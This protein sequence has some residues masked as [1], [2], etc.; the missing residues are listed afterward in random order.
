MGPKTGPSD[1]A[2]VGVAA[3]VYAASQ[4]GPRFDDNMTPDERK[5]I[6]NGIWLCGACAILVD[7]DTE[8]FSAET[9]FTWKKQAE[10]RTAAELEGFHKLAGDISNTH[11]SFSANLGVPIKIELD[12]DFSVLTSTENLR[13]GAARLATG[14]T[15]GS[16]PEIQVLL[17]DLDGVLAHFTDPVQ[18]EQVSQAMETRRKRT[19]EMLKSIC[20]ASAQESWRLYLSDS[21]DYLRV[22]E[23]ILSYARSIGVGGGQKL[24]VFQTTPPELYASVFLDDQEV[25]SMLDHLGFSTMAHLAFGAGWRAAD[26]LPRQIIQDKVI[27]AI[28]GCV[29]PWKSTYS[30]EDALFRKAFR[31]HTWHIG[32]G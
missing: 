32:T 18:A 8:R 17:P 23:G 26:E 27:P 21:G 15:R 10:A 11:Q 9:L 20:S 6:E 16:C 4:G 14:A 25:A 29:V 1:V 24:D 12:N 30:K 28:L 2:R 13:K 19:V 31:L 7:R 5:S 3:H 22:V